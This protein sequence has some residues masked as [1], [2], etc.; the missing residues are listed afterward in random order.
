MVLGSCDEGYCKGVEGSVCRGNLSGGQV[1]GCPQACSG[2]PRTPQGGAPLN[3][4]QNSLLNI[5]HSFHTTCAM[6]L[7]QFFNCGRAQHLLSHLVDFLPDFAQGTP[8][9]ELAES[10]IG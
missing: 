1:T 4:P 6:T 10:G 3:P 5:I 8:R 7:R 9:R 2:T